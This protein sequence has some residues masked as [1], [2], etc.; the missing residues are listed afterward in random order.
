M[1]PVVSEFYAVKRAIWLLNPETYGGSKQRDIEYNM[2]THKT[3]KRSRLA[4]EAVLCRVLLRD[5]A[6][7]TGDFD[8]IWLLSFLLC[9]A[10]CE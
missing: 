3:R 4:E 6:G 1:R 10:A 8:G 9:D 5:D 7:M 2:R